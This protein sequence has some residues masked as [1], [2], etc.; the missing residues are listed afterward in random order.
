MKAT[1]RFVQQMRGCAAV[2]FLPHRDCEAD[3]GVVPHGREGV[4][5][6]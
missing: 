4:E 2:S 3:E 5:K 6:A 1:A